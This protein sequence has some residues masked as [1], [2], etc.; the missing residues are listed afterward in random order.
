MRAHSDLIKAAVKSKQVGEV[1]HGH[2]NGRGGGAIE[3][4]G[5]RADRERGAELHVGFKQSV[6]QSQA[7][8][9]ADASNRVFGRVKQGVW[10]MHLSSREK[11]CACKKERG[12]HRLVSES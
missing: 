2:A 11:H 5:A 12:R 9:L 3:L 10:Q 8:C 7:E 6:W 1:V 4:G